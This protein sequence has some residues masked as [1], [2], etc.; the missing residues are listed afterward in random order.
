VSRPGPSIIDRV[1][2]TMADRGHAVPKVRSSIQ[3]MF[4]MSI[5]G[6]RMP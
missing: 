2:G 4:S 6:P 1:L 3:C 5:Y